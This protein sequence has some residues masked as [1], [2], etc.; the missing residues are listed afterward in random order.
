[1]KKRE[2]KACVARSRSRRSTVSARAAATGSG[3]SRNVEP[4]C[5][6]CADEDSSGEKA[7]KKLEA[8]AASGSIG[9]RSCRMGCCVSMVAGAGKR[10]SPWRNGG[11]R[12][13]DVQGSQ[14]VRGRKK[15]A[16]AGDGGDKLEGP[17]RRRGLVPSVQ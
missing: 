9:V 4:C 2:M 13:A 12:E 6:C 7:E 16:R 11:W 8:S 10:A 1:M 3:R 14:M 15:R 17:C 5:W